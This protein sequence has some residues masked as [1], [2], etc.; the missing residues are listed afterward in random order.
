M[1]FKI[2]KKY[3]YMISTKY[4]EHIVNFCQ[5]LVDKNE[6]TNMAHKSMYNL[7]IMLCVLYHLNEGGLLFLKYG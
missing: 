3:Y 2:V 6:L 7:N 4:K 5:H 1:R